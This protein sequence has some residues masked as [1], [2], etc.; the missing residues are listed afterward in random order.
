MLSDAIVLPG[1]DTE[2]FADTTAVADAVAERILA[3]ATTAIEHHGRF[4]LCLAGGTTPTAAYARLKDAEADWAHWWIYHGDE[5]CSPARDGER[6]SSAA[7]EA[8]LDHVPVP[9]L[10]IHAIPVELGAEIGA[11]AYELIVWT[12]LPF[13]LVLLGMGEDGHTASLFP[14]REIPEDRLVMPVFDAPK[15]PPD[16]VSLT[17][18]AL[19]NSQQVLILVTGD[20]K[21]EA[22]KRWRQGEDLP[23]ARVARA[24]RARSR[25][26]MDRAAAA[27]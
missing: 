25:V 14:G 11:A 13:D 26:L 3:A 9:R 2:L 8:W 23:I 15:P 12:A 19:A 22:V 17:L 1:A 4:R 24:A 6:N 10:Q 5:R 18:Q 27:V 21:A 20:G 16:R 7:G